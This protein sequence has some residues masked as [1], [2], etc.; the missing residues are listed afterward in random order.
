MSLTLF[1][2]YIDDLLHALQ[3]ISRL[4][5]QAFANDLVIWIVTEIRTEEADPHPMRGL[6]VVKY[7]A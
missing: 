2:I 5:S 1:L 6:R 4:L 3:R 7:E